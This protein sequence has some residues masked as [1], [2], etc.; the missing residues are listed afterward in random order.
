MYSESLRRD[1]ERRAEIDVE[2]YRGMLTWRS[3]ARRPR[4]EAD[5][6]AVGTLDAVSGS[7]H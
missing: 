2:L 3:I 4:D 6:V 7:I 1:S 5:A